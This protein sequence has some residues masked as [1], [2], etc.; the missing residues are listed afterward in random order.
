MTYVTA[1]TFPLGDDGKFQSEA[2][3]LAYQQ[4]ADLGVTLD[5]SRFRLIIQAYQCAQDKS[6]RDYE[7]WRKEQDTSPRT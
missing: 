2:A 6:Q 4:A 1:K 7:K 3:E 5:R